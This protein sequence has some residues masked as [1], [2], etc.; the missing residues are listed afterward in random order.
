V[1]AILF[2]LAFASVTNAQSDTAWLFRYPGWGHRHHEPLVVFVDD[3]GNVS[4]VGW[5]E[6]G[7]GRRDA[8]L[9][10]IDSLGQPKWAAAYDHFT[11]AGATRDSSGNIYVAG[12]SGGPRAVGRISMLKYRPDGVLDWARTYGEPGKSFF[13]LG[14]IAI[15][16]SQN[17]YACG[18]AESASCYTVRIV[19]YQPDGVLAGVWR[20]TL[21]GYTYL[22]G[23]KF[24][25]IGNG[26]AY[27]TLSVER[28]EVDASW[29][30]AKLAS[31][32]RVLWERVYR[33]TGKAWERLMGSQVDE[34]ANIFLTGEVVS[35]V[36]GTEVFYTM[37]MDSSG[38]IRWTSEYLGSDS[39][40]GE[41]RFL[42]L[43][44]GNVHVSG[45]NMCNKNGQ[46][47]AIAVVKYDSLGNRLWASQWGGA[48]T[49]SV[50]GYTDENLNPTYGLNSCSMNVDDSGDVYVTGTGN[51]SSGR[52]FIFFAVLLKYDPQ[53]RLVWARKR[54][55]AAWNG[56]VVGLDKRGALYD[57]GFG[58]TAGI[59]GIYVLKYRA[60]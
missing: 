52:E 50:P 17:V 37:K 38:N 36:Y 12:V 21:C 43:A 59:G 4:V 49:S 6:I 29:Y 3:T 39:L 58:G 1:R 53:G 55:G 14:T 5:S 8:L 11:A 46:A 40:R 42:V 30:V 20:Y 26:E 10:K 31:D 44:N 32:S 15:D 47:P 48:D 18:A 13:D 56:A 16:D 60:R 41:P 9:L 45:W 27:L 54:V 57:V 23:G 51:V 25:I 7:E 2:A 22:W 24:H 28:P 35:D 34:N 33:D 19:K